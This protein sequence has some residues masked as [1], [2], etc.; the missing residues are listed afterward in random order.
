MKAAIEYLKEC[1]AIREKDGV[2]PL[3]V[4]YYTMALTQLRQTGP[5]KRI[6]V[7][8]LD[9]IVMVKILPMVMVEKIIVHLRVGIPKKK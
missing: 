9:Y 2:A 6:K 8:I 7:I 4:D 5:Q 3:K 1:N